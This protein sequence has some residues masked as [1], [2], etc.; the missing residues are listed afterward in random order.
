MDFGTF[1]AQYGPAAVGIILTLVV[2]G[3]LLSIF[4]SRTNAVQK[5]G[6]GSLIMLSLVS[7]MIP[8]FW[9]LE[10]NNQAEATKQQYQT[11][12][13]R[14]MDLYAKD[15]QYKCYT[16][17]NGKLADVK[18]NGYTIDQL[19]AM[20]DDDLNRV[21]AG[22]V[23]NPEQPQ[24]PNLSVIPRSD[25]Y[26]GTL[27]SDYVSYLFQFIRSASPD[28]LKK[29]TLPAGNEFDKLAEYLQST[30]KAQYDSAVAAGNAGQFGTAVDM[31]ASKAITIDIITAPTTATCQPACFDKVNVKVKVG[32]VITWVNK[33]NQAHTV[34][35]ITG[36]NTATPTVAKDIFDSGL[37]KLIKT[38]ESFTYTVTD[39]AFNANPD[40]SLIYYCQI[41]PTMLAQLTVVQ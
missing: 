23:Y 37:D 18:Y 30:Y 1:L 19:N 20:N 10:G 14:G 41:H 2:V 29:H 13:E 31:T 3:G 12:L 5:T 34:S 35:A 24:P 16:I 26:G 15:C 33:D 4:Y 32:T 40:H 21:I 38:G 11:A 22:G 9:V 6:F 25:Q 17:Q 39:A 36:N 28:Y 27:Q 7:L 8:V